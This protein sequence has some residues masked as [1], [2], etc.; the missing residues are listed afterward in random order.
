V[1]LRKVPGRAVVAVAL[2][3]TMLLVEERTTL[4][5][6]GSSHAVA[7]GRLPNLW[8]TA[9]ASRRVSAVQLRKVPGRAV[10]AVAVL[11]TTLLVEERTTLV[12]SGSSHA[13]VV[14]RILSPAPL[15]LGQ[16]RKLQQQ[17]GEK[18]SGNERW[19]V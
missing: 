13:V 18:E 5:P 2:L 16:R 7:V 4:V 15:M 19:S 10:V 17:M 12:P 9:T 11:G 8:V 1:Q 6:S 14:A 3:G